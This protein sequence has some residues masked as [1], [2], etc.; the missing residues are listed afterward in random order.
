MVCIVITEIDSLMT[1]TVIRESISVI[2]EIDSLMTNTVNIG[3]MPVI[4]GV[5]V[6]IAQITVPQ[7]ISKDKD[8]VGFYLG[9]PRDG[10]NQ[11]RQY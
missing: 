10:Y 5:R 11:Q 8:D 6:I 9:N 2:T 3:C 4:R 1:N 7:I